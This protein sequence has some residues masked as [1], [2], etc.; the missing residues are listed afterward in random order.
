MNEVQEHKPRWYQFSKSNTNNSAWSLKI[1]SKEMGYEVIMS[2][3]WT[4]IILGIILILLTT[5]LPGSWIDG[6]I[7]IFAGSLFGYI[8]KE[9][10]AWVVITLSGMS[11]IVTFYNKITDAQGGSNI[12]LAAIVLFFAIKSLYAVRFIN[13]E[14]VP[15]SSRFQKIGERIFPVISWLSGIAVVGIILLIV[16]GILFS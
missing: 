16:V 1:I 12:F 8:K 13:G 6:V 7:S 9:W 5:I 11:L 15:P 14:S 2:I 10:T 3:A 4:F